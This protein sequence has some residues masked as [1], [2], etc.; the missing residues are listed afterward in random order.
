M[1][2][3]Y[4]KFYAPKSLDKSKKQRE[5][6]KEEVLSMSKMLIAKLRLGKLRKLRKSG[7][8]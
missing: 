8:G 7:G 2:K 6:L 3:I 5:E 4:C 1:I